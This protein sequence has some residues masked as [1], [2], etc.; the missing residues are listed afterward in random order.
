MDINSGFNFF[1]RI[2]SEK[3][4]SHF[5]EFVLASKALQANHGLKNTIKEIIQDNLSKDHLPK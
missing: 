5:G 2:N 4:N 1:D 3:K